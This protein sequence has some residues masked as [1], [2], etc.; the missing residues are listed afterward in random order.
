MSQMSQFSSI[1]DKFSHIEIYIAPAPVPSSQLLLFKS[2]WR[3]AARSFQ[4]ADPARGLLGYT[5][6][7]IKLNK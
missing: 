6:I 5:Q 4:Q 3:Q 2:Q 7:K 1:W